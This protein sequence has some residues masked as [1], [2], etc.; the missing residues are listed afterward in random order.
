MYFELARSS[1][2]AILILVNPVTYV[3]FPPSNVSVQPSPLTCAVVKRKTESNL[4]RNRYDLRCDDKGVLN[5]V[6][7]K[8]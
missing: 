3:Q 7:K 6:Q 5:S 2:P 1:F 8:R 4:K